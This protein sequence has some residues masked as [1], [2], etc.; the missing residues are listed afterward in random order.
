MGSLDRCAKRRNRACSLGMVTAD[1]DAVGACFSGVNA[2]HQQRNEDHPDSSR[3]VSKRGVT[4]ERQEC[5]VIRNHPV[6][7]SIR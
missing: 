7:I 1:V 2:T 4:T 3:G 6:V 5:N